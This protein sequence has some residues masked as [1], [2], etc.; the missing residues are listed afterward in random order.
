MRGVF[1]CFSGTAALAAAALD[2]GFTLSFSGI[3]TFPKA[4]QLRAVAASVPS[5]RLLV[6]TDCPYLAPAPMRGRRNEPA[7]VVRTAAR[8]AEVRGVGIGDLEATVTAN[9]ARLFGG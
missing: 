9:F 1:H 8:L 5:D 3:L 7:L 6:E 2:L 4:D